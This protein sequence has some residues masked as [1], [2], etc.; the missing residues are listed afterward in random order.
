MKRGIR[1]APAEIAWMSFRESGLNGGEA[2]AVGT[3]YEL[4]SDILGG[5]AQR[6]L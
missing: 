2:R 3:L 5:K 1:T 4:A 6:F